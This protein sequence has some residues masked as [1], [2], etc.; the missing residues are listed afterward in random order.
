MAGMLNRLRLIVAGMA[1][2]LSAVAAPAANG[3][4]PVP[5][6]TVSAIRGISHPRYHGWTTGAVSRYVAHTHE[7]LTSALRG[8]PAP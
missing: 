2:A 3:H 7:P 4:L 1:L 6:R 5:G 8:V